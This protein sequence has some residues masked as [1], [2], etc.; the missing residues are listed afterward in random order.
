[1]SDEKS[2]VYIQCPICHKSGNVKVPVALV[3]SKKAGLSTITVERKICDH[4]F[5]IYVDKNFNMRESEKIEYFLSPEIVDEIDTSKE[6]N[7]DQNDIEKIK[8][9]TYPLMLSYLLK[10]FFNAQRIGMILSDE[11]SYLSNLIKDFL[12]Y[13]FE[14]TFD[15]NF[16]LYNYEEYYSKQKRENLDIVIQNI[17]ILKDKNKIITD[18]DFAIE[19]GL[20]QKFYDGDVKLETIKTLKLNIENAYILSKY[21]KKIIKKKKYLNIDKIIKYLKK[22][23][24]ININVR[25]AEFLISIV[26]NYYH[27]EVKDLYKNVE[28]LKFKKLAK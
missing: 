23:Y 11:K 3:K 13:L 25:Y 5:L 21:L 8:L 17:D 27:I 2:N 24:N 1:M 16:E 4:T 6:V 28:V 7:F 18:A 26:K 10:G 19:R 9:N 20:I 15:I 22:E 12:T 14:G